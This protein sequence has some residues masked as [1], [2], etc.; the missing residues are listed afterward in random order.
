[1][2]HSFCGSGHAREA[3]TAVDG[4][5]FARVRGRARSHRVHARIS[6]LCKAVALT[7]SVPGLLY[8]PPALA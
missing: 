5:G 8:K 1:M 3:S 4:T 6:M 2:H 7:M